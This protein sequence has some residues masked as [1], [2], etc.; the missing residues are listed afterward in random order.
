MKKIQILLS[1]YNGEKYLREQLN[2]F[3]ALDNFEEIKVLIRDDGSSDSTKDI[4]K[5]YS[6]RF[7]F[8]VIYGENVGVNMSFH[9]LI[10]RADRSCEYFAFSDQDDVWL[11]HKL[12]RAVCRISEIDS[13]S[14]ALY[15][16]CSSLTDE[17][18]NVNG[19]TLIPKKKLSFYNAMVQNVAVGHTQVFNRHLLELLAKEFS[20]DIG[21]TDHWAYLLASTTGQVMY[22]EEQT[23]LYRQHGN[24]L[25][26]YGNSFFASF[27]NR[28]KRALSGAPQEKTRQL[29]AF[30]ECYG[31]DMSPEHKKELESFLSSQ[32]C[33]FKRLVYLFKTKVYR[34]TVTETLIFRLM[35]LFGRYK[36]KNK[37]KNK[38]QRRYQQ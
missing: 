25:I 23:A 7:G 33:F 6:E 9:Q 18:L 30:L 11:P 15:S 26:G 20:Q 38:F 4:L 10:L 8:E 19:H 28:I 16:A 21:I 27:K 2:S 37:N 29:E 14:C 12:S 3:T 36:I 22:D 32:K 5:E 35:Y 17:K 34:Q 24:N 13:N 1:T 31:S